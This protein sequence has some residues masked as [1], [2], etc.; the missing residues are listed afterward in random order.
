MVGRELYA[1]SHLAPPEARPVIIIFMT[2][3]A[4]YNFRRVDGWKVGID[5]SVAIITVGIGGSIDTDKIVHL[6]QTIHR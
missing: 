5:G 3:Y 2:P 1:H 6:V 4:L